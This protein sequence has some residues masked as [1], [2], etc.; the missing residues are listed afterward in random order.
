MGC[1][2]QMQ[3]QRPIGIYTTSNAAPGRWSSIC[4]HGVRISRRSSERA[5]SNEPQSFFDLRF[6]GPVLSDFRLAVLTDN[7]L[8]IVR[9]ERAQVPVRGSGM[10]LQDNSSR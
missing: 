5:E 10:V 9:N 6:Q 3:S 4:G 1:C 2:I 7:G 8:F